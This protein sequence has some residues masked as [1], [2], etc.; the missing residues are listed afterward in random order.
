MASPS[1]KLILCLCSLAMAG[2]AAHGPVKPAGSGP[3]AEAN[4]AAAVRRPV[5]FL[6]LGDSYTI[7]ESVEP[8]E[9]WPHQLTALL[10]DRGYDVLEPQIV[11]RT[12]WTT[13]ELMVGLDSAR[14]EGPFDLVSLLI[15]VNNQYRGLD[16]EAYRD[17]FRALL[18]RA[19]ELAGGEPHR[20]IVLSIPDWGA[21]PFAAGRDREQI[22]V[23][24]DRFNRINR[25]EAEQAGAL[26][27]DVTPASRAAAGTPSLIAHDGLH[28]SGEMYGQ[29]A[30]LAL[31]AALRALGGAPEEHQNEG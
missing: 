7:G 4:A 24:V 15:G 18:E 30:H 31:P 12:G 20:V 8:A 11:A 2:C 9:R 28:P 1:I 23:E 27:V 16:P 5:R 25:D 6:A 10:Q 13:A 21:T 29:W 26:Y 3:E 19:I 14:P 17:E 22:A